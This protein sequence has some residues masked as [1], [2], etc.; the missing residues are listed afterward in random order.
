LRIR[1]FRQTVINKPLMADEPQMRLRLASVNPRK[2]LG[3][4]ADAKD[5][6]RDV[7]RYR[8][9]VETL[10]HVKTIV[11]SRAAACAERHSTISRF[12]LV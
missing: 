1:H 7:H 2:P 8:P 12:L 11:D 9:S 3:E 10:S 5:D 4:D 6:P